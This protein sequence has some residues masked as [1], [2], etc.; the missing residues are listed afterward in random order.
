MDEVLQELRA[1]NARF[2]AFEVHMNAKGIG[3]VLA[4]S[5]S[6]PNNDDFRFDMVEISWFR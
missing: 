2:E 4:F 5:V 1:L 6:A 3:G